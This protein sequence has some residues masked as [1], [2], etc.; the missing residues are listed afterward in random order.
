[1]STTCDPVQT[2]RFHARRS[3]PE[4]WLSFACQP[5][6]RVQLGMPSIIDEGMAALLADCAE[7]WACFD[8]DRMIAGLTIRETFPGVVGVAQAFLAADIGAAHLPLTRFA[9][10]RVAASPLKRI[11]A[12]ALGRDV[13]AIL[14]R[15]P[16]FAQDSMMMVELAMLDPTPECRWAA[17]MGLRA[18]HVVRKF[19]M[20]AETYVLFERIG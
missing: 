11:E 1:M 3:T 6:Q 20:A 2:T 19:G 5:S 13:E 15:N 9:R 7:S 8:G 10:E 12:L 14:R 16:G 18:A 4:D 17:L